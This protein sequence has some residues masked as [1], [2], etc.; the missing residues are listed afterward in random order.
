MFEM[1]KIGHLAATLVLTASIIATPALAS[2]N[3]KKGEKVFN[4]CK[5][6]HIVEAAGPKKVGPPL[7]GIMGR[8]A[9]TLPGFKY[10]ADL[11]AAGEKG[12]VWNDETFLAYMKDTKKFIGTFVDKKVAKT[13][14]AFAGLKKESDREDLLA[15]IKQVTK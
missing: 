1:T 14:M 15:Y 7:G 5:T 12:L 11:K 3:A 2:G 10:S 6:C 13:T 4:K 9:G 8:K